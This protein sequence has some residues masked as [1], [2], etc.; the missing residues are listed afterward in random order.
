MEVDYAGQS[1][2]CSD[3]A[4]ADLGLRHLRRRASPIT[5]PYG[6]LGA[7]VALL[8]WMYLSAYAF[9]FGAELNSEIEHQTAK[10]STTGSP[11]PMGTRGAWAA[12]NVAT[13]DTVSRI[14]PKSSAKARS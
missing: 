7:V 6:S 13:D 3:L 10:D 8:T 2:R 1:I 11:E 4:A 12:D 5:M 14:A 9:I